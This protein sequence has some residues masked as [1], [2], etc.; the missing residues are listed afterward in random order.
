MNSN[1]L[2]NKTH[3]KCEMVSIKFG[4]DNGISPSNA[5]PSQVTCTKSWEKNPVCVPLVR[6][7]FVK[8]LYIYLRKID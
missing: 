2:S 7:V 6:I 8:I 1:M 5:I 4:E 3:E